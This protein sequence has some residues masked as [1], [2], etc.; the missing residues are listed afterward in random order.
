MAKKSLQIAAFLGFTAIILG[1]FGAHGL[2]Q[3][4]TTDQLVSFESGVKYQMYHALF[5]LFVSQTQLVSEKNEKRDYVDYSFRSF[6][7][8][9]FYLC[10]M[11]TRVNR[12]KFTF[13]RTGDPNR[14]GVIDCKLVNVVFWS[15]V[16]KKNAL[17]LT[18][19]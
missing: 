13:F 3:V 6:V 8:F 11:F 17:I 12:C 16:A 10:P 4:L 2:K 15:N 5:L 19:Y 9:F 7:I 1:A 18:E 14:R